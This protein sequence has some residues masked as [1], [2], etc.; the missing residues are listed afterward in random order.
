MINTVWYALSSID[1]VT[2]YTSEKT[3]KSAVKMYPL[4][5]NLQHNVVYPHWMGNHNDSR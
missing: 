1:H 5:R 2:S 3:I 4:Y